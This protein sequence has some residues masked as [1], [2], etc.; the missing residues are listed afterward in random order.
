MKRARK[1]LYQAHR[2]LGLHLGLLLFVICATGT[3]AVLGNEF[4]A[5]TDPVYRGT[6]EP[7]DWA[8][9]GDTLA[10]ELPAHRLEFVSAPEESGQAV[11]AYLLSPSG[12]T[13]VALLD[14]ADGALRGVRSALSIQFYLR[15]Y[16]KGL[17][18]PK[19]LY[20]LGLLGFLLLFSGTTGLI[21]YKS[22]WNHLLRMRLRKG[23]HVRWMDIHRTGGLWL[24]L[25]AFVIG[26]TTVWYQAEVA[27]RDLAD[28]DVQPHTSHVDSPASPRAGEPVRLGA[29]AEA[30]REAAPGFVVRGIRRPHH[31]DEAIRVDGRTGA[32]L[33]RDR[34]SRV[35]L[36]PETLEPVRVQRAQESGPLR[37]W[38]DMADELHFGSL[39]PFGGLWS[40][41]LWVILGAGLSVLVLAGSVLSRIRSR[42]RPGRR[43]SWSALAALAVPTFIT[44]GL[45]AGSLVFTVIGA[46]H[47]ALVGDPPPD[48]WSRRVQTPVGPAVVSTRA[49]AR[50]HHVVLAWLEPPDPALGTL[51][52]LDA[53]GK[54]Y[55]LE[56]WRAPR[57]T[58]EAVP[59][60]LAGTTTSGVDWSTPLDWSG[61]P[62]PH[63]RVGSTWTAWIGVIAILAMVGI[64]VIAWFAFLWVPVVWPGEG[65]R[66]PPGADQ[67]A[68][69]ADSV[70]ARAAS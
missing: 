5:L 20:V 29:I 54:A 69:K 36:H 42:G 32:W 31:A 55:T 12:Q 9:V 40:K 16:H 27:L 46:S 57:A 2:W 58:I 39:A 60:V 17:L 14:P 21:V 37:R 45:L 25:F 11:M 33:V 56:G 22:W 8:A 48:A 49:T 28:F 41:V 70:S 19:S 6:P 43:P 52:A 63:L 59:D 34:A 26:G 47:P 4:D 35:E 50:G 15:Q 23:A 10:E 13:Q 68:G 53:T 62:P 18:V 64:T 24:V 30:A 1:K 44:V 67:E 38:S 61:E 65:R 3:L 7:V 51:R 66:R